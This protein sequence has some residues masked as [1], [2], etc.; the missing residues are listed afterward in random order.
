MEYKVFILN[1]INSNMPLATWVAPA[2]KLAS[3]AA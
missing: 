2:G 1:F 3:L